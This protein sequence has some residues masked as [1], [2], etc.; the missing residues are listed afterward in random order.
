MMKL[1]LPLC[2]LFSVVACDGVKDTQQEA[3]EAA[4]T[5]IQQIDRAQVL[6]DLKTASTA[7]EDYFAQNNSYP[8]SLGDLKLSLNHPQ[9]LTYDPQTGKVYSKTFPNL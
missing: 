6:S 7:V 3:Q 1:F 5:T 8:A 2:L 4:K 9:D